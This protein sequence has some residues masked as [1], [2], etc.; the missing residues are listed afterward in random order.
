M[1]FGNDIGTGAAEGLLLVLAAILF[2][3][4]VIGFGLGLFVWLML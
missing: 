4:L 1:S 3:G 2:V